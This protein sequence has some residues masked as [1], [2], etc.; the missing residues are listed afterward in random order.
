MAAL[1]TKSNG[2]KLNGQYA[3][4]CQSVSAYNNSFELLIKDLKRYRK[5]GYRVILLSGSKTR[6]ERLAQDITDEGLPCFFTEDYDHELCEGQ[7][8]VCFGKVRRGFEYPI[9]KFAVITESDIF[10]A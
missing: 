4:H 8:M 2:I 1:D 10:G 7:I 9:L 6:A 3:I 5:N